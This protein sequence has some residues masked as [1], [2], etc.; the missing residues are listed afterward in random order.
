MVFG[1]RTAANFASRA[2]LM[3]SWLVRFAFKHVCPVQLMEADEQP[4]AVERWQT[5]LDW[6]ALARQS[7]ASGKDMVEL[8]P[9]FISFF[10]DDFPMVSIA[11][12]GRVVLTVFAALLDVLGL[13]PQMKKV[14]PEGD[15]RQQG[16]VMGVFIDLEAMT[17]SIPPDK[18]VKAQRLLAPFVDGRQEHKLMDDGRATDRAAPG[19]IELDVRSVGR[20]AVPS[21]TDR[22]GAQSGGQERLLL[23]DDRATPRVLVV[24]E[25]VTAVELRGNDSVPPEYMLSP[26]KWVDSPVTGASR[27]LSTL[28]GAGGA[29]YNGM[30]GLCKWSNE[31][32]KELDIFELEALMCVLWIA[33]LLD[34]NPA[35][36]LLRG[37]RFVFRNDNKPWCY[38]CNDKDSAK[39]AI[40]V[41]YWSGYTRCSRYTPFGCIWTGSHQPRIRSPTQLAERSGIVS[42][43]LLLLTSI[44]HPLCVVYRCYTALVDSLT[45]DFNEK[46]GEGHAP[47]SF[48]PL[49]PPIFW[50]VPGG[51]RG[52]C[53]G[54]RS[55]KQLNVK[56]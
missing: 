29:F 36:E 21:V 32:V 52:V 51:G 11:G 37:R 17:A 6:F 18:V 33:T 13:D 34:I 39:P 27:E 3:L 12:F 24:A 8:L 40:A 26:W 35:S 56:R 28:S 1:G 31:E 54:V 25:G 19:A 41:L 43:P 14:V 53:G 50:G 38:A 16:V 22:L 9:A 48:T 49:L 20:W 42:T 46:M 7:E 30:W 15:F 47:T 2:S 55:A 23:I 5:V 10:I 44:P 4:H 45:H